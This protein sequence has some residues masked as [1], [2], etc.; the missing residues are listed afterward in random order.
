MH[1]LSHGVNNDF[2]PFIKFYF[3]VIKLYFIAQ[4]VKDLFINVRN[5]TPTLS[6]SLI[7]CV[8]ASVYVCMCVRV[9]GFNKISTTFKNL[10]FIMTVL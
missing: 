6:L 5:M 9:T 1:C 8:H 10:F 3:A 2:G 7:L 4:N